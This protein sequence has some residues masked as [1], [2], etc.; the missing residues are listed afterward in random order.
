MRNE[1]R[2]EHDEKSKYRSDRNRPDGQR[3]CPQSRPAASRRPTWS[4]ICD[5]R[6]EVAQALADELG[7]HRVVEDYHELLADPK[8]E[9]VL[10]ATSTNTHAFIIKDAALAGKHIFC[11]KPL[12]LDLAE[13]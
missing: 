11:E 4:A 6:L 12:A 8:I 5:I 1:T 9:A 7:I 2:G 13:H 3:P 10:I